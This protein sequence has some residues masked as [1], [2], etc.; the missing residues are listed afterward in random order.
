MA[1]TT[2]IEMRKRIEDSANG[3]LDGLHWV[4]LNHICHDVLTRGRLGV[5]QGFAE[6]VLKDAGFIVE[7]ENE[8]IT[9]RRGSQTV[10]NSVDR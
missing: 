6:S 7:K 9:V 2:V 4:S 8:L 5:A 1:K 10:E 3:L